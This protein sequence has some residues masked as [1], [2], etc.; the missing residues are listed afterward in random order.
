MLVS[1]GAEGAILLDEQGNCFQQDAAQGQ[2]CN[3]VGAGDSMV[4]G[5]LTGLLKT[6]HWNT[7]L[8]LGAT[9]GAAT[10]FSEG[11]G[12]YEVVKELYT[13][14]SHGRMEVLPWIF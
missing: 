2:V 8:F 4:A 13:Q 5:V 14:L 6:E 11:I 10:A 1:N 9:A 7:A 12:T 3:S